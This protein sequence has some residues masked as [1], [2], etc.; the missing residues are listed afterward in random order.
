MIIIGYQGIGKS[1]LCKNFYGKFIDLESGNFWVDGKRAD[2]W[3]KIYA[4]IANHLSTQGCVVFTSSHEVVRKALYS[5]KEQ[6]Y[7][8]HPSL[9][10]RDHWISKLKCRYEQTNLDKDY[11]AWKNAESGY[12][13][14]IMSCIDDPIPNVEISSANYDLYN[15]IQDLRYPNTPD[16]RH[17]RICDAKKHMEDAEDEYTN[18][19]RML[20]SKIDYLECED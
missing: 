16:G 12:A 10:L 17:M 19:L 18:V 5:S 20:A 6:V 4:N 7:I 3:Y 1:T 8:V 2:D 15:I 13:E 11:K 9:D 14:Q